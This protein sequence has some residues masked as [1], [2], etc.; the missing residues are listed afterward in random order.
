MLNGVGSDVV[1][2]S[3]TTNPR[4]SAPEVIMSSAI[5]PAADVYSFAIIMWE[6]LTWQQPYE[7]MMSV[8]SGRTSVTS[9]HNLHSLIGRTVCALSLQPPLLVRAYQA[10]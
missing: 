2:V 9:H 7:D 1:K 10:L 3:K 4:W 5:G 8:Q 6:M